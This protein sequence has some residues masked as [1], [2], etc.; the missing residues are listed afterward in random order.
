V[1]TPTKRSFRLVGAERRTL[2]GDVRSAGGVRPAVVICGGLLPELAD[3]LA[4]AGFAVVSFDLKGAGDLALVLEGLQRGT[5][6]VAAERYGLIGHGTGAAIAMLRTLGDERVRA[7]VTV[8]AEPVKGGDDALRERWLELP[9][10]TPGEEVARASI[11]WLGRRL[12]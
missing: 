10:S 9:A 1:A 6:G 4:R 5:V 11:D 12:R 2:H 3:R 7:L 8:T